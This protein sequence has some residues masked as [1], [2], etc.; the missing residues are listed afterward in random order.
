MN[1]YIHSKKTIYVLLT[2]IIIAGIFRFCYG[3][4][5]QKKG[6]HSDEEWSFGL[7]NSYYEPYIYSSDDGVSLKNSN[8]WISGN[9]LKEYL[10]VQPGE[11]FS[12]DSVF[13]NMSCDTHP[14]LYFIILHILSSF[15]IN[16]YIP[17][18]GLIINLVCYIFL[19]IYLYRLLCLI[20]KS[21]LLGIFGVFFNTFTIGT[22]SMAIYIRMYMMLAMFALIFAYYNAVL[23]Y[24]TNSRKNYSTYIKLS[25]T[26]LLGSLTHHFFLP[27]AFVI[28]SL[29]FLYWLLKKEWVIL[30]KYTFSLFIGIGLSI[31]I[32]P[33]T[34]EH[35]FGI[36]TF[37]YKDAGKY[38][39]E[40]KLS[41]NAFDTSVSNNLTIDALEED[42][43]N[44]KWHIF[45][46][47]FC[48]FFSMIWTDSIGCSPI[49]PYSHGLLIYFFIIILVILFISLCILFLF[50]KEKKMYFLLKKIVLFFKNSFINIIKSTNM[51]LISLFISILSIVFLCTKKINYFVMGDYS[52]RY[53]FIIYP[54]FVILILYI[55]YLIIKKLLLHNLKWTYFI[56]FIT[57]LFTVSYNNLFKKSIYYFDDLSKHTQEIVATA[58]DSDIIIV[59]SSPWKLTIYAPLIDN[60][61]QFYY[62]SYLDFLNTDE[63]ILSNISNKKTYLILDTTYLINKSK[64]K[65]TT[66]THYY[67]YI[68]SYIKHIEKWDSISSISYIDDAIEFGTPLQIYS[69]Q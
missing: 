67:Q 31:I 56:L 59:S 5:M 37:S 54:I 61:H 20:S 69:L 58:Y 16:K 57:I 11:Q 33:A 1:K 9:T 53:L 46:F 51:Y 55:V 2:I 38:L 21:N 17:A 27:Y 18:L 6:T 28:S 30:L 62:T 45:K 42:I 52:N 35:L 12:I 19:S 14:P 32:F 39:N 13:Y 48:T 40:K 41:Y 3:F 64:D 8:K 49:K 60:C 36:Q 66:T 43:P 26:S 7:A 10:T 25:I 29:L 22:L 68:K 50:R 4:F 34:I 47:C 63:T 23:Y 65:T 24:S 44:Y 15:F